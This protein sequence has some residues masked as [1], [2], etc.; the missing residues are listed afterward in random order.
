MKN[1]LFLVAFLVFGSLKLNA[2]SIC[3]VSADYQT[4]ED[5]LIFWEQFASL[6]NLDSV[7][8]YRKQGVETQFSKIG[9]V[10]IEQNSPT[11]FVDENANTIMFSQYAISVLDSNSNET[12][13][14][15]WHQ[16]IVLDYDTS[17]GFGKL[18]W[19][20]YKKEDQ[21]DES[22]VVGYDYFIDEPGVGSFQSLGTAM[23][24]D[25]VF[26]D[27]ASSSH[28]NARYY[29]EATLPTCNIQTKANINT[30][31]SNIKQQYSNA[32]AGIS[33]ISNAI[34]FELSPNPSSDY[35][36]IQLASEM[37]AKMT[38]TD[39]NGR[40]V[41]TASI[42]SDFYTVS[43]EDLSN[44]TYFVNIEQN[45]VISSKKFIKK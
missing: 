43:I 13:L 20:K 45:D 1:K 39:M 28:V 31:R 25:S 7:I 6:T 41:K 38:I 17:T 40:V 29:V 15:Y 5:Y 3:L 4:G 42:A 11:Y 44:G 23:F 26:Y 37:K 33:T 9:A 24:Y 30:S 12:A 16:P 27:Q 19:T 35:I 32:S 34:N 18:T 36:M 14:S 22:Y 21:L 10:D 8:V 2:Q